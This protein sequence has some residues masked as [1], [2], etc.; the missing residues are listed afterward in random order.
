MLDVIHL[1]TRLDN[2]SG[3]RFD[4]KLATIQVSKHKLETTQSLSKRQCVLYKKVFT[5]SFELGV[6][7]L[8]KHKYNI[9]SNC[10]WLQN[11]NNSEVIINYEF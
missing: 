2:F 11:T 4:K 5:L 8:L 6:F 7:F 1:H 3:V 9:P 10:V